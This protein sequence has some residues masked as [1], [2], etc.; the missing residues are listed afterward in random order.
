MGRLALRLQGL[1]KEYRLRSGGPSY[2]TLVDAIG[3]LVRIPFQ[4]LG[5][6]KAAQGPRTFWA[7]KGVSLEV[8]RGQVVGVIGRNGAG[9]STLLK[10]LSG[11]TTPTE[12]SASVWGTLGALLEVGTGFHFEL[13]GRE[14]VYLNG[15]I[16]GMK[17]AEVAARFDEI[18]AFAGVDRFVDTPVKHYSS[19]MLMR[20]AFAV[21]SQLDTD[22]LVVDE[23]LA[24]GDAEFQRKCLKKMEQAGT[25]G[26]TVV[27][28]SHDMAAVTRLCTRVVLL[29]RGTVIAD[30]RAS[31]VIQKYLHGGATHGAAVREWPDVD[32]APGDSVAKL[33]AVRVLDEEGR[34]A[35]EADV[36]RGIRV[37]VEFWNLRPEE[38]PAVT[39]SLHNNEGQCL[40]SSHD[41]LSP[42][43]KAG[44]RKAG[45]VRST[46]VIPADLLAEGLVTVTAYVHSRRGTENHAVEADAVAFTVTD[47][48][49]WDEESLYG[50]G[51]GLVRP[52]LEWS[53]R[54][55]EG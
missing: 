4:W 19:G 43:W 10:I 28:V 31:E 45:L 48:A 46:C 6:G 27:F 36:H 8:P 52:H 32:A 38:R 49:E 20:L 55:V 11:V 13:T 30:G 12:G 29:D 51:E 9:K 37:E 54:A 44:P 26:R 5:P 39:I 17:R 47:R 16:L 33:R 34:P 14:N 23:V 25:Q 24:V 40:L 2:D 53:L 41:F 18:V 22:V 1:G 3:R 15:A 42:E 50:R 21:A 7:L 35:P